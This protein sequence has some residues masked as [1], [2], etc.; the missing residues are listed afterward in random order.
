M[1]KKVPDL[2]DYSEANSIID[3]NCDVNALLY[4]LNQQHILEILASKE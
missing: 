3:Y 2:L 1:V 4:E